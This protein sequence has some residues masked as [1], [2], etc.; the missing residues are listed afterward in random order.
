LQKSLKI[1]YALLSVFITGYIAG[2]YITPMLP[3]IA[4][5]FEGDK[6]FAR[7]MLITPSLI[8]VPFILFSAILLKFFNK[9]TLILSGLSVYCI[10]AIGMFLSFSESYLLFFRSLSGVGAGLV[11]PYATALIT[12]Y[13]KDDKKDEVISKSGISTNVGGIVI[14]IATGFFTSLYW[15]LGFLVPLACLLPLYLI[16]KYIEPKKRSAQHKYPFVFGL[17]FKKEIFLI[18]I[19]YFFIMIFVFNYFAGISFVISNNN[20]G[21]SI[22]S[23]I[24]QSFYMIAALI[25][26]LLLTIIKRVSLYLLFAFQMLFVAQGFFTLYDKDL[27]LT[28]VYFASFLIG[29]GYGAFFNSM[30]SL[31]TSYTTKVNSANAISLMVASMYLSQFLSPLILSRFSN[32]LNISQYFEMFLIEGIL[33]VLIALFLFVKFIRGNKIK[34]NMHQV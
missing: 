15:R 18:C 10:S 17:I 27:T 29:M 9:K 2:S 32:L 8:V 7:A 22:Q 30:L 31:A 16:Y 12:D 19:A 11:T 4:D 26:N 1:E 3:N 20:L 14:L 33:F 13:Y 24:A 25:A 21:N 28:S 5:N 34:P 6:D 23:G